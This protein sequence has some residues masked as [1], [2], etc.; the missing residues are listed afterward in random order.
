MEIQKSIFDGNEYDVTTYII[1]NARIEKNTF[2]GAKKTQI[3]MHNSIA[4]INRNNFYSTLQ[5]IALYLTGTATDDIDAKN[6]YWDVAS[7]DAAQRRIQDKRVDSNDN[8]TNFKVNIEPI[9]V[10]EFADAYPQ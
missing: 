9:A 3:S 2:V 4:A 7:V 1:G 10:H 6:N 5:N 8:P